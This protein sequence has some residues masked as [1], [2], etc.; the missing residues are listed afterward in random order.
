LEKRMFFGDSA[1]NKREGK[2]LQRLGL[3]VVLAL[4]AFLNLSWLTREAYANVYY[5]ATVKNMLASWHNFFFASFDAGFVS[6]DKPPLGFWIQAASAYVFGF[7]RWSLLLPQALAGVLCVALLHSRQSPDGALSS[8]EIDQPQLQRLD[9][10]IL[11]VIDQAG[12]HTAKNKLEVPEGIHLELLPS[13]S[14][15]L[16][17]SERLWPLSNE[18][19][20]NRHFEEIEQLE[21]ALVD[22]CAA[23]SNQPKLIRYHLR[24]H[25]WPNAA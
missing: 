10:G 22:R 25:W 11:L 16:Q 14:P 20:A 4:S 6:V 7:H 13:D 23:L 9:Y 18:G 2:S 8:G 24:Y 12:W 21:E 3:T 15:E 17:P 5:A 19:V 1:T